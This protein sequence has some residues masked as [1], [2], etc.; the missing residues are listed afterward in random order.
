LNVAALLLL[1]MPAGMPKITAPTD[2]GMVVVAII[3]RIVPPPPPPPGPVIR[4]QPV[5]P[6]TAPARVQPDAQPAGGPVGLRAATRPAQDAT[7]GPRDPAATRRRADGAG[8]RAAGRAAGGR[9]G[10]HGRRHAP[11]RGRDN[12]ASR[13]RHGRHRP[14]GRPGHGHAPGVRESAR[15]ALSA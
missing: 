8:T 7:A 2:R 3:E 5:A 4:P 1:L 11:G 15:P 9:A 13:R 12:P 14:A 6:P 10:R